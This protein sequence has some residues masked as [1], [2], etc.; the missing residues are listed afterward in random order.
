[1]MGMSSDPTIRDGGVGSATKFH[2]CCAAGRDGKRF[3][4]GRKS[5]SFRPMD[6]PAPAIEPA[7]RATPMMEQYLEIKAA[8]PD[9]L[10][11]YRIGDFYELFLDDAEVAS[12]ALGI[13]LTNRGS[14][15]P[16]SI[17]RN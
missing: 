11:F 14:T 13:T 7:S 9:C 17:C 6:K 10:L 1:M 15:P 8:N 16:T 4:L 2:V 3:Y 12:R 5:F